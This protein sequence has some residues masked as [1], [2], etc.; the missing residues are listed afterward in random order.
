MTEHRP[1][2]TVDGRFLLEEVAGSGGMGVVYRARDLHGGD[3]VAV[4]ILHPTMQ[5]HMARF[6]REARLLAQLDHPGIVRHVAHGE[7]PLYLAM[8]WLDGEDLGQRLGRAPLL[9][10]EAL[11][12]ARRVAEALDAAHR[13][14]VVHRDIKPGNIFL[15]GGATSAVKLLDFGVARPLGGGTRAMTMSGQILGTVGYMAPEQARE[16]SD[17]RGPMDVFSLGCV[18]FECI[19]GAPAFPGAG[20]MPVLAKLLFA[21]MPRLRDVRDDLPEPLSELVRRMMQR[22]PEDRPAMSAVI[23]ELEALVASP[24]VIELEERPRRARPDARASV[25]GD[26]EQPLLALVMAQPLPIADTGAP[27]RELAAVADAA[28]ALH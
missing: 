20:L 27:T 2:S 12:M 6:V 21:E 7:S 1:G 3:R 9:V 19:G 15:V 26:D 8:E 24:A 14:G 5:T 4:K 16:G 17:V 18:L 10:R 25:L 22:R 23:A 11:A 13:Q 28:Q